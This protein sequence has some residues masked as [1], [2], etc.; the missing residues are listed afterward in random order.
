MALVYPN[1]Y[2]VGM[3]SLALHAL[4][5]LLN[6]LDYVVAERAF[7]PDPDDIKEFQRTDTRL[8]TIETQTSL[9]EFD[10][11]A[12]SASFEDDYLNIVSVLELANIELFAT[13]RDSSSPLIVIGGAAVSL[14]PEPVADF[15]DLVIVGDGERSLIDLID[16]FREARDEGS[17]VSPDSFVSIGGIY[18]PSLYEVTYDGALIKEVKSLGNAPETVSAGKL[19]DPDEFPMPR[20]AIT[21]PDTEFAN[22]VLMEIEKGCGRACRFCAA[23]FLYLPPRWRDFDIVKE[24]MKLA[25]KET[26]KVGLVGAAVSEYPRLKELLREAI[27]LGGEVTLSSIRA[28][29]LDSEL[30]GLLKELGY[31]T[32]TIAP[33]AGSERLRAVINKCTDEAGILNVAHLAREAGFMKLK[34]Y[35]LAGLPTETTEDALEIVELTKRIRGEF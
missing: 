19:T 3:S 1:T 4:Y 7:L 12:F 10:I 25:L 13:D 31:K 22:T 2:H 14:N 18:V 11:I 15:F 32:L 33:E 17:I 27:K 30:A 29:M 5:S 9:S 26:G 35:F 6:N 28:E 23:G 24:S 8:F 16:R 20:T 34:L 21:T